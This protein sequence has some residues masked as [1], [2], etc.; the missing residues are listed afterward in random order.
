MEGAS[1]YTVEISRTPDVAQ[2]FV[3]ATTV[4]RH[5]VPAQP[6]PWAAESSS[7]L[8]WR[9]AAKDSASGDFSP[10][11]AISR[12]KGYDAPIITS[13]APGKVFA[14]P[15][16]PATLTWEPVPGAQEYV[17]EISQDSSFTDPNLKTVASTVSTSYVV[18]SPQVDT[19]YYFKVRA[20]ISSATSGATYSDYSVPRSYTV[21][22]L[23][24]AQRVAPATNTTVVDDSVLDWSPVLGARTYDI[25]IATDESFGSIVHEREDIT[26]TSYAR[27]QSLDNDEYYWRVRAR[28]VADNVPS[29]SSRPI[30]RFERAWPDLPVPVHPAAAGD[31]DPASPADVDSGVTVGDPFYYEWEPTR[32]ASI[33]RI[34]IATN[35]NFSP[36]VGSCTTRNTT[37]T[38]ASEGDGDCMPQAEGT[39]WWRVTAVDQYG[40]INP[41]TQGIPRRAR[42]CSTTP[43]SPTR[44]RASPCSLLLR[45]QRCR[46]QP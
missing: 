26:G 25:Q 19:T 43:S 3:S 27:P 31:V 6:L 34:D 28:D 45:G 29:W 35:E 41:D 46:C 24:E 4:N 33:Y 44:P 8:Y 20:R 2:R 10:W 39:Y 22:A 40:N 7:T 16:D 36:I 1:Q 9:V 18:A 12:I 23:P 13:P 15:D 17:V 30:W 38:P 21:S 32:L 11:T 14:Q 42:T 37:Y 5:Y